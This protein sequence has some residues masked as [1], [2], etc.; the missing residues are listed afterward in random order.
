[1]KARPFLAVV[2]AAVLLLLSLAAAGWWLVLQHSPLQLQ[3]QPL[4]SPRAAR[5]VPRQAP[6]SLYLLTDG[7]RPEGYARAVAP[8][9]QRRQAADAVAGLRDGAFAAAGLDYPAEL[10]SW[11]GP[12]LGLALL[13]NEPGGA[14]D[15]W[16]LSLR[17]RDADGAHRFLQR[18]WQTRSLAGTDLQISSYRGMGLISGRGALVGTKPVPIATALVNDDLVLIASGRGVLEQALD[19]SQIDELNQ[20]A[21]PSFQQALGRLGKGAVLLTAQSEVM[22]S[23]LGMPA[24]L[25]GAGAVQ[26]LVASLRP[27]GRSLA[28]EA[29]LR[30][31]PGATG[32]P[33]APPPPAAAG[34]AGL[35]L[36]AALQGQAD[37]L[38]L[39]Q[40]PSRW[41]ELWQ[42]LLAAVLRVGEGGAE[43]L[44]PALVAAADPGPLLWSAGSQGWLLGTAVDQPDPASLEQ[45]LAALGLTAAPLPVEGDA[46]VMVWTRLEAPPAGRRIGREEGAVLQA[47]LAG[48]RASQGQLAWWG[49]NLAVLQEQR[50]SRQTPR[51]RLAQ[52]A[53]LDQPQASLQWAMAAGPAQGLLQRWSTWQLLSGLAGRPLAPAVQGLSL[54]LEPGVGDSNSNSDINSVHLSARVGFG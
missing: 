19:V 28:L 17:S 30:L 13:A 33:P 54:S 27:D 12:E 11:L 44:L 43:G 1:M 35:A 53:A 48:A 10:A 3:Y 39:V 25:T 26:E 49:Q 46:N 52:L 42:P 20:A 21:S 51:L 9:R 31:A 50:E 40:Q 36:L 45:G 4:V 2:L 6:L 24:Q 47:S 15:G 32:L 5:F 22:G 37:S 14:A 18:F 41:P 8:G 34:D 16:L 7:Q 29:L 38:A 23:W